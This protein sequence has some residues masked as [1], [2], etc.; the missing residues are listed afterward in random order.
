MNFVAKIFEVFKRTSL[1]TWDPM[2]LLFIAIEA[3]DA[4]KKFL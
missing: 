1:V 2:I 4:F 3:K